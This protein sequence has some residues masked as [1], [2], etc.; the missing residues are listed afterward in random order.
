L[1]EYVLF[2]SM[3]GF[4]RQRRPDNTFDHVYSLRHDG[5]WLM[6][7]E[8]QLFVKHRDVGAFGLY[9]RLVQAPRETE[10]HTELSYGFL[11]FRRLGLVRRD[12]AIALW[13]MFQFDNASYGIQQFRAPIWAILAYRVRME[14]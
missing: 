1:N 13:A 10:R 2:A 6:R 9:T 4:E 12:D 5:G 14:L 3:V 11:A 8:S 7:W